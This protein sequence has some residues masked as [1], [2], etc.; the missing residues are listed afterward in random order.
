V[1]SVL[2]RSKRQVAFRGIQECTLEKNLLTA[3][4]VPNHAQE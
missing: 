3:I 2:N 1:F 4:S